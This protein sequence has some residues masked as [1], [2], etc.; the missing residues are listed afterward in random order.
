MK[1]DSIKLIFTY[2][3]ALAVLIGAFYALILSPYEVEAD[4]KLWL[5]GLAGT[6]TMFVFGEQVSQR[7]QRQA[8][9]TFDQGLGATPTPAL[10]S[11]ESKG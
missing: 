10:P 8:Q 3:I 4:V 9:S 7:T 6:A 11:E 5:T 2:G 1:T